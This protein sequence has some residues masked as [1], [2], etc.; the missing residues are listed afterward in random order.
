MKFKYIGHDSENWIYLNG[1]INQGRALVD[2]VIN[3]AS[4]SKKSAVSP[5]EKKIKLSGY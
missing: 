5:S 3:I 2:A 4:S 1:D